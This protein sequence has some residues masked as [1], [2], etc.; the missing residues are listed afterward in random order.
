MQARGALLIAAIAVAQVGCEN[1]A[2]CAGKDPRAEAAGDRA[3]QAAEERAAA[4]GKG[5]LD[6]QIAGEVAKKRAELAVDVG[7]S[8]EEV[9][10]LEKKPAQT[11]AE[12][13]AKPNTGAYRSPE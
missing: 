11:A 3:E 12:D 13:L 5:P 7:A 8:E 9:K 10:E 2:G 1:Q 4:E 6:R